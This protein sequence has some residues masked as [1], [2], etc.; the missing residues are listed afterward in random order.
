MIVM[1]MVMIVVVIMMIMIPIAMVVVMIVIMVPAIVVD[2]TSRR[3]DPQ[4][5][6]RDQ[7]SE[8]LLY[9]SHVDEIK[10]IAY[11]P[12]RPEIQFFS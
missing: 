2:D 5:G 9:G 12:A 4:N 11:V 6:Q 10:C 3:N 8:K 1:I 7:Y